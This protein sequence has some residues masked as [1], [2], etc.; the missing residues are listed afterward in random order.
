[1]EIVATKTDTNGA[2]PNPADTPP[3]GTNPETCRN[4]ETV[5]WISYLIIGS[6]IFAILILALIAV[7]TGKSTPE[8]ILNIILPVFATWVGTVIAFYFGKANFDAASAQIQ[9]TNDQVHSLL[10]NGSPE[11]KAKQPVTDLMRKIDEMTCFTFPSGRSEKDIS[12]AELRKTF[13]DEDGI[14]R[15]PVLN[16]DGYPEYMIH[17]SRIDQYLAGGKSENDTL[18]KFFEDRK[19][20]GIEF[21]RNNGFIIVP[22]TATIGVAKVWMEQDASCQDIFVTKGGTNKE[23]LTGWISNIRLTKY[24][25]V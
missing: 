8:T 7:L 25:Q 16:S 14:T 10:K 23:R 15:L 22:E 11:E 17:A 5:K 6:G 19:A 4:C 9:K 13:N 18:E 12:L 2:T 3:G 20:A 1:M 21:G 24:L